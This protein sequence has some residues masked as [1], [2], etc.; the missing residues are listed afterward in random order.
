M[1]LLVSGAFLLLSSLLLVPEA[2]AQFE[3]PAGPYH[4]WPAIDI[5]GGGGYGSGGLHWT[6]LAR[7][8]AGLHLI[9]RQRFLS[10]TGGF[11][12]LGSSHKA[13]GM[14]VELASI[15]NGLGAGAGLTMSTRGDPGVN[16]GVSLSLLHVEGMFVF[17]NHPTNAIVA[18]LR[19][20]L[21]M[22]AQARWGRK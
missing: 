3:V 11:E 13:F 22:I 2:T 21:G 9:N 1:R 15:T 7:A 4:P 5:D 18:Y 10:L 12:M 14:R 8:S 16:V 19:I 17:G 6:Y 20:P